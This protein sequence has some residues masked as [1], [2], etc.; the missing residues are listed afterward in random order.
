MNWSAFVDLSL[1]LAIGG[2]LMWQWL[3][4][5]RQVALDQRVSAALNVLEARANQL[6]RE[7]EQY[8]RRIEEQ[9]HLLSKVCDQ[10][11]RL[12]EKGRVN[13]FPR[14]WEESEIR[15]L[16]TGGEAPK[17]IPTLEQ[18]EATRQQLKT[19]SQFDLKTLLKDQLA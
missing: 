11:N 4:R 6:E 10:A 5:H 13:S 3:S 7:V 14:S 8:R 1:F 18:V 19:E 12:L 9:I 17:S 16:F 2:Y 15:S